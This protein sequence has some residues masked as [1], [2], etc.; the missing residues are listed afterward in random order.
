MLDIG[1][2]VEVEPIQGGVTEGTKGFGT[3]LL[4]AESLPHQLRAV[5]GSFFRFEATLAV[6][7]PADGKKNRLSLLL[8]RLDI[9]AGCCQLS[10]KLSA[11]GIQE[12]LRN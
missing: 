4:G 1:F 2:E 11:N 12:C 6:G 8:T 10:S 7:G 3:L 5:L 9:L